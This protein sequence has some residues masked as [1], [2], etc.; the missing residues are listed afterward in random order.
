MSPVVSPARTSCQSVR[1]CAVAAL[2]GSRRLRRPIL[3]LSQI[4]KAPSLGDRIRCRPP[5]TGKDPAKFRGHGLVRTQFEEVH[6]WSVE[7][8]HMVQ[9]IT[10]IRYYY[11]Q[12]GYEYAINLNRWR[13]GY[14]VPKLKDGEHEKYAIRPAQESDIP[15]L[16]STFEYG[17]SRSL[18]RVKWTAEHWH[19]NLYE[20]S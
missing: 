20:L 16:M 9:A 12:F 13:M 15:F 17:C 2:I 1:A 18:V 8:G 4:N 3:W 10:G 7:R 19:N 11:R 14:S 5:R 6:K